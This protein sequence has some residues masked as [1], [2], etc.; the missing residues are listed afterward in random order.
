MD[1][2]YSIA[3][4]SKKIILILSPLQLKRNIKKIFGLESWSNWWIKN[5]ENPGLGSEIIIVGCHL[6]STAGFEPDYKP[7]KSV[8]AGADDAGSGLSATIGIARSF[9]KLRCCTC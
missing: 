1:R 4:G 6:D 8:E 5:K 9:S 3:R 2:Q 7:S